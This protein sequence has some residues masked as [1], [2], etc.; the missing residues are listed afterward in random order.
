MTTV[1]QYESSGIRTLL[2]TN[3]HNPLFLGSG[4]SSMSISTVAL[5]KGKTH[6]NARLLLPSLRL[7]QYLRVI[8]FVLSIIVNLQL[9]NVS[10]ISIIMKCVQSVSFAKSQ[11]YISEIDTIQSGFSYIVLHLPFKFW[12]CLTNLYGRVE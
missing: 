6:V 5:C 2:H 1:L 12:Y 8:F 7:A 10:L 11:C 9:Y 3:F 4:F